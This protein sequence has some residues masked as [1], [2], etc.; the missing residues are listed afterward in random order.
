M[1][2]FLQRLFRQAPP[3]RS[4]AL[5]ELDL[6]LL[7]YLDQRR[8]FFIEAGANDGVTQSNTLFFERHRGWRGLLVEPIPELAARCRKNRQ[9]SIVENCA[10][11][12]AGD[13]RREL[14]MEFC[15]LMS[16]VKGAM[17][18][19]EADRVHIEKG[20]AVQGIQSYE[21]TVPAR[22][23]DDL[24]AAY[25]IEHVDL[26][27]LD[28]EGFELQVLRGLTKVKPRFLLIEARDR[29]PIEAHLAPDYE[30]IA[31]LSHHDVLFRR[32]A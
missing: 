21:V 2:S 4:Y 19:E 6:K 13:T 5:N 27:S 11:L 10:L 26:F 1:L 20:C 30:A 25:R 15:N 3:E 22:T 8:G 28:V 16:L 17:Q 9:R 14:T 23:L 29:A 31:D 24:L 7:P 32:R 12:S 18:S